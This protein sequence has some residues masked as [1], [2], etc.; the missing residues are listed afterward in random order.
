MPPK[1]QKID[2]FF[3][4]KEKKSEQKEQQQNNASKIIEEEY[5][6]VPEGIV[7]FDDFYNGLFSWQKSLKSQ[8]ANLKHI[9]EF[10]KK[11]YQTKTCYPPFEKIFNAFQLTPINKIKVVIVGQDPYINQNEAMGLCFS[12][13][14]SQTKIPPSLKNVYK[15]LQTDVKG[16]TT[17]NHGDLTKWA[18]QGVFLLNTVLTVEAG[19]S[20][21]HKDCGWIK[22]TDQVIEVINRE[23]SGLV[24]LLWGLPAQK[25][26]KGVD[27]QKHHI[28]ETVHPSPL[29]A[30]NGFFESN[31]FSKCN[32]YLIQNG[33]QPIDWT[34]D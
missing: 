19:K 18:Q 25:K 8:E 32:Q 12:V 29:S 10:I 17:P 9:Y 22:F 26:A 28:L 5:K 11:E 7:P 15:L 16:F 14:R 23:C 1:K 33:K 27:R 13:P 24:F 31:H 4:S 3:E 20:N 34:L 6:P 2:Q 21:S 30:K